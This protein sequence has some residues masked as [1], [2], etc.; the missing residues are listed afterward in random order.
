M[1]SS[2]AAATEDVSR[3]E[4]PYETKGRV[5]PVRGRRRRSPPMISSD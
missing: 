5:T 4:P 1:E 3:D 2:I